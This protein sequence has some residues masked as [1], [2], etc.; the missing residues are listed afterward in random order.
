MIALGVED[1]D[2]ERAEKMMKVALWCVQDKPEA[3]PVMSVVV[4]MLE[5][6]IDIPTPS[7]PF[8][9]ILGGSPGSEQPAGPSWNGST[10]D[11]SSS[12]ATESSL[13]IGATPIMKKYEIEM[14]ASA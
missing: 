5:G 14:A 4:K 6:E 8:R 11:F 12:M 13:M 3:R 1:T 10:F 7:Y 2:R 9:H